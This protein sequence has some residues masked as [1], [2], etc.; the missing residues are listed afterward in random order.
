[1]LRM[2]AERTIMYTR[3][4]LRVDFRFSGLEDEINYRNIKAIIKAAMRHGFKEGKFDYY[5]PEDGAFGITWNYCG[6][7]VFVTIS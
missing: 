2:G 4:N 5:E 6:L 3:N 1:M 7:V